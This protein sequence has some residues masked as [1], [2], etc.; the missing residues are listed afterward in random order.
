[1]FYPTNCIFS[2][3][4]QRADSIDTAH[5]DFIDNFYNNRNNISNINSPQI[6]TNGTSFANDYN[7]SCQFSKL[8]HAPRHDIQKYLNQRGFDFVNSTT[9]FDPTIG[10]EYDRYDLSHRNRPCKCSMLNLGR[11]TQPIDSFTSPNRSQPPPDIPSPPPNDFADSPNANV[12][13]ATSV[14]EPSEISPT[15][16]TRLH[17]SEIILQAGIHYNPMIDNHHPNPLWIIVTCDPSLAPHLPLFYK[18]NNISAEGVLVGRGQFLITNGQ[19]LINSLAPFIPPSE[20]ESASKTVVPSSFLP[21]DCIPVPPYTFDQNNSQLVQNVAHIFQLTFVN[22]S[23]QNVNFNNLFNGNYLCNR[24]FFNSVLQN[25]RSSW[26]FNPTNV[27]YNF[28]SPTSNPQLQCL[29]TISGEIPPSLPA[30][31]PAPLVAL[32]NEPSPSTATIENHSVDVDFQWL[33]SKAKVQNHQVEV[34]HSNLITKAAVQNHT[35]DVNNQVISSTALVQNHL[36]DVIKNNLCTQATVQSHAV[37][38]SNQLISSTANVQNHHVD[39]TQNCLTTQATVQSHAVD[40]SNQL[41]SS[42]ANVQNH[43]IDVN[44]INLLSNA[45]VQNHAVD[46]ENQIISSTAIVQNHQVDVNQSNFIS[47][48]TV[49]NHTVD[50]NNHIISSTANVQSHQVDVN[51]SKLISQATV[52]NHAVEVQNQFIS[53]TA[54]IQNH[55]VEV[56]DD[57]VKTVVHVPK[58]TVEWKDKE[59]PLHTLPEDRPLTDKI[60][61]LANAIYLLA[62]SRSCSHTSCGTHSDLT[63]ESDSTISGSDFHSSDFPAQSQN[64]SDTDLT[65][66]NSSLTSRNSDDGD[67]NDSNSYSDHDVDLSLQW[68]IDGLKSIE[69]KVQLV[70]FLKKVKDAHI[71]FYQFSDVEFFNIPIILYMKKTLRWLGVGQFYCPL[72]ED[73]FQSCA[74]LHAHWKFKHGD[75][76]LPNEHA[77]VEFVYNCKLRWEIIDDDFPSDLPKFRIIH[78]CPV[79]DCNYIVNNASALACHIKHNHQDL[80]V[81]RREIG[82]LW[83]AICCHAKHKNK[84][85]TGNDLFH[86]VSGCLCMRCKHFIGQDKKKVQ[87]HT[88]SS[89]PAANVEG[90]RRYFMNISLNA[91]WLDVDLDDDVISQ[92]NKDIADA[93][94]DLSTHSHNVEIERDL[95]IEPEGDNPDHAAAMVNRRSR[96]QRLRARRRNGILIVNEGMPEERLHALNGNSV[97]DTTAQSNDDDIQ[98]ISPPTSEIQEDLSSFLDK[99]ISWINKCKEENDGIVYLPKIWGERIQKIRKKISNVFEG[100]ISILIDKFTYLTSNKSLVLS[101]DDRLLLWN[102]VLAKIFLILRKEIRGALH[103]PAFNSKK[104]KKKKP[105]SFEVPIQLKAASKFTAGI[106]LLH[107]LTE[108]DIND[109]P[110]LNLIADL[111]DKLIDFLSRAPDDF[112]VLVGGRDI[113]TVD[114]ILNAGNFEDKLSF[115]KAKLF[116]LESKYKENS[117]DGYK[118]FIQKAYQEDSKKTLDWFILN[119][120]TPECTVPVESFVEDY[121]KAWSEVAD[122]EPRQKF[123]LDHILSDED[124]SY[125]TELLMSDKSIKDAIKSRSNLSAVGCDGICNSIWKLGNDVSTR[126]VKTTLNVMLSTGSFPSILKSCKT[127]MLY[128]KGEV[129]NTRSWRPITITSTLYRIIM[130]HISRTLQTLNEYRRFINCQQKGFMKIP[131]GAAEHIVTADEMIHHAAR[132]QKNLYI[133]TIDF[134]DAFGSIPHELFK[135]NLLDLGFD[136]LFVKSILASYKNASTRIVSNGRISDEIEFAKGVKQGCPLSPTLFNVGIEPLLVKLNDLA[137]DEGYHWYDRSTSVQA[138]ADDIVLFSDSEMG[139]NNLIDVVQSFCK[140]AGN[141]KIN[142]NKCA[143]FAFTMDNRTRASMQNHF[144]INGESVKNI[145]IQGSLHYLGLPLAA[146]LSRRKHHIFQKILDLKRDVS[147]ITSSALRTMQSVD[148]IKK[149]I[150]P[151]LDYELMIN[152]VSTTKLNELD[153]FIRGRISKKIGIA[154]VPTDWFY[155][156]KHDGG[157]NLQCLSERHK[158]LTIRLYMGMHESKDKNVKHFITASDN[159]EMQFRDADVQDDSPFLHVP[160]TEFGAIKG[161]NRC[162]TSNLLSRT[163]KALHDLNL[164]MN[165]DDTGFSIKPLNTDDEQTEIKINYMKVM[166]LIMKVI[167]KR[168]ISSL[169]KNRLKGHTFETLKNSPISNFYI[170]QRVNAADSIVNFSFKARLGSLFTGSMKRRQTHRQDDGNCKCCGQIETIHHLL[171]G[172]SYRKHEFTKRHDAIALIINKYITDHKRAIVHSNQVVRSRDGGR[173]EGENA[174]LKP[175][176]FWWKNDK[177][178]IVEITI[179]YGMLTDDD[180]HGTIST[181]NLRRQQ[182]LNKYKSLIEDC[183]VQF[184]C[185]VDFFVIV[186]SSLGAI[187]SETLDELKRI[188]GTEADWKKIAKQMVI[189]SLRES[190]FIA[191]HWYPPA[192][193]NIVVSNNQTHNSTDISVNSDNSVN[194]DDQLSSSDIQSQ[195]DYQNCSMNSI[196]DNTWDQ[197]INDDSNHSTPIIDSSFSKTSTD[198]SSDSDNDVL[199]NSGSV[200]YWRKANSEGMILNDVSDFSD[201]SSTSNCE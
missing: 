46:I 42:T 73:V 147:K 33:S 107:T 142:V 94:R 77:A 44:S 186:V 101:D 87:Q 16:S 76:F 58:F 184:N 167:Q 7:S 188:T 93:V 54:H 200:P 59:I 178:H 31:V 198:D 50:V 37:D 62:S 92:S 20:E 146:K 100:K 67:H 122:F 173:L 158:A 129:N 166:K 63:S 74:A 172:C 127:I 165:H 171:N 55:I 177:L 8:N 90:S 71:N 43:H 41:I 18:Q 75:R 141:M 196:D 110:T 139:M 39:V 10:V 154:G 199:V 126:I 151:Q 52:Q 61:K 91:R 131:S 113:D 28:I 51:Q 189:T 85:L 176:L 81:L 105:R 175:D 106:E 125:F 111:K 114:A 130:C 70:D 95:P 82:L 170:S 152:A 168:H 195:S 14:E 98:S 2:E 123:T 201:S 169:L 191:Y 162:G 57:T 97:A 84:L 15:N 25:I 143:S 40:V 65:S 179:P 104:K 124:N 53:S 88:K 38:V 69:T 119:S 156:S 183:K 60:E 121:G 3:S 161:N 180:E 35:V 197:L 128:K 157:L 155:S 118:K 136:K 83:A 140:Y 190:M 116:D 132:H 164:Q 22:N 193:N 32:K 24:T 72:C 48:A 145:S 138:Y 12:N 185:D 174:D 192:H 66:S 9:N 36:V 17:G 133:L 21:P 96:E 115:L 181:L 163:V 86:N 150:L 112:V 135:K 13:S 23:T 160:V 79:A 26:S 4:A 99:T 64:N 47:Q 49:Q 68:I 56:V 29:P 34:D 45:T 11:R 144:S 19:P 6:P 78:K 182:K 149:F 117:S 102:G 153:E 148:A 120:D 30:S 1:M 194:S 103:I 134:K 89:H 109:Q 27:F 137:Q 108:G 187:P 159:D 5:D 80:D